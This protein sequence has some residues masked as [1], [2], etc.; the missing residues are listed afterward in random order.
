MAATTNSV[1]KGRCANLYIDDEDVGDDSACSGEGVIL[2][3]AMS[4]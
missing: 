4:G 2:K 1:W 3:E